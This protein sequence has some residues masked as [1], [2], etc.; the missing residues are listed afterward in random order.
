MNARQ[1]LR[2]RPSTSSF[3]YFRYVIL[4]SLGLHSFLTFIHKGRTLPLWRSFSRRA[5]GPTF[6]DFER[7]AYRLAKK[8][9]LFCRKGS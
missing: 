8:V 1:I 9:A 2:R 4:Y 7:V 5:T 3:V 6:F